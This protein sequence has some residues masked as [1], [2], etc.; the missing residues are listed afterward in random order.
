MNWQPLRAGG[1]TGLPWPAVLAGDAPLDPYA[2]WIDALLAPAGALG[3]TL[4]ALIEFAAPCDAASLQLLHQLGWTASEHA[5][6]RG[7]HFTS[8]VAASPAALG[9]LQAHLAAAPAAGPRVLRYELGLGYENDDAPGTERPVPAADEP[10]GAV[11]ALPGDFMAF[12]DH[13]C[14]FAHRRLRHP[15]TGTPRVVALWNQQ[16]DRLPAPRAGRPRLAWSR[17]AGFLWG[18]HVG[19]AALAAYLDACGPLD[20]GEH[21]AACYAG[22]GYD[23]VRQQVTHGTHV[24]DVATGGACSPQEAHD[25]VFVQLPRRIDGRPV[26]GLLRCNVFDALQ[27]VAARLADGRRAV[28]NVSYGGYCG[29]HDGTALIDRA[30]DE[31]VAQVRGRGSELHVVLPAGNA[32]DQALHAQLRLPPQ[33]REVIEWQNQPNDPTDSFV[34]LWLPPGADVDLE[35]VAPGGARSGVLRPGAAQVLGHGNG[36]AG[37]AVAIHARRACQSGLGTLLLLAVG[38][39]VARGARR[40]APYGVWRLMLHNRSTDSAVTLDAWCERDDPVFGTEAGPRQSRFLRHV[41]PLGTLNSLAHGRSTVVVGGY[42]RDPHAPPAPSG[43]PHQG[44]IASY[45]GTGPRR[46][47]GEARTPRLLAP[48]ECTF[49]RPGLAGATVL[50]DGA[51]R[52]NGTSVAAAWA[53]GCIALNG[54][55]VPEGDAAPGQNHPAHNGV[56]HPDATLPVPRLG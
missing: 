11:T 33:G 10:S 8:A 37:Q 27:Y 47:G 3:A 23:A 5:A 26:S 28:V 17:P 16:L 12:V 9:A 14:A 48:S 42:L 20:T 29:P 25:I 4:P 49:E 51:E 30:I 45:S 19:Q 46:L 32:H 44:P 56:V 41:E 52:M 7:G 15:V 2:A 36:S 35:L 13:G 39:T 34:E 18:R 43:P 40:P 21:E 55:A 53:A 50:G 24:M 54:F 31:L 1:A 6:G 22:A 38:P